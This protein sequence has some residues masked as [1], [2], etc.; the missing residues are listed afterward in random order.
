MFFWVLKSFIKR[1]YW[2]EIEYRWHFGDNFSIVSKVSVSMKKIL[3]AISVENCWKM[4]ASAVL[5]E[6]RI[7]FPMRWFI[8]VLKFNIKTH[9]YRPAS[10]WVAQDEFLKTSHCEGTIVVVRII[11]V[12]NIYF[13]TPE[14]KMYFNL[15]FKTQKIY[16]VEVPD[17]TETCSTINT[18]TWLKFNCNHCCGL[19]YTETQ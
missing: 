3:E 15:N 9:H 16:I 17:H 5:T 10:K 4:S 1:F 18:C 8:I 19:F 12:D 7:I 14:K 6:L 13:I 2:S 11:N